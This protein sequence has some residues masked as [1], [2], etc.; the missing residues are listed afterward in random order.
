MIMNDADF[1]QALEQLPLAQQ[2]RV[3]SA[4]VRNVLAL[5]ADPAVAKV[6]DTASNA[7]TVADDELALAFKNAKAAAL[8]S[9]TR[10]GADSDW[11]AQAG[12]FVARAASALVAPAKQAK[13]SAWEAAANAR[14]ART[15]GMIESADESMHEESEAQYRLLEQF[16]NDI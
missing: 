9:H 14:L 3:G 10:C 16:L 4:F 7:E 11:Q 12:Y 6:L 8:E 15:C 1:K 5:S 2:R 13:S